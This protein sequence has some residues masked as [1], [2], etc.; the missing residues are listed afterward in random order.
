MICLWC[1]GSG[2][3]LKS[4]KALESLPLRHWF[5]TCS[6]CYGEGLEPNIEFRYGCDCRYCVR[7]RNDATGATPFHDER[8]AL[9]VGFYRAL[10]DKP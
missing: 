7:F 10:A 9:R 3:M 2:S 1:G 8:R 4:R 6:S 5:T